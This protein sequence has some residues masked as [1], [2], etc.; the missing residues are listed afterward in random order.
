MSGRPRVLTPTQLAAAAADIARG[1]GRYAVAEK[2]GV[3]YNTLYR[4]LREISR[5]TKQPPKCGTDPGYQAH[6]KRKELACPKCLKAH[7]Q[8]MKSYRNKKKSAESAD[9]KSE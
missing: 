8:Y 7:A 4:A 9:V 6:R 1:E 2:Y 5:A 3:H